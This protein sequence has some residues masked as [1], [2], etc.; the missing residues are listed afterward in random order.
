MQ[1]VKNPHKMCKKIL[2]LVKTLTKQ[3][4]EKCEESG[5]NAESSSLYHDE[6]LNLMRHR[7]EKL[8]KDFSSGEEFDISLIPDIYDSVKY[9]YV[10]N[11]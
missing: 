8:E 10:H 6:T 5:V 3:I 7:W 1:E 4:R 9:D 2:R 11:R